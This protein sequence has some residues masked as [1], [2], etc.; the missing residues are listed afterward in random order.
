MLQL[1]FA[2][3]MTYITNNQ[4]YSERTYIC[5]ITFVDYSFVYPYIGKVC[6][7][8]MVNYTGFSITWN[9]TLVGVTVEIPCTG[10]GLDGLDF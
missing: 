10:E 6:K 8:E 2:Y 5:W 3:K 9:E 4:D 1:L 7:S